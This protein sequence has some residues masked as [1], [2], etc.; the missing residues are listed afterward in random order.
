MRESGANVLPLVKNTE[1]SS[2]E[3]SLFFC[4]FQ[5][6]EVAKAVRSGKVRENE[7]AFHVFISLKYKRPFM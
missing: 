7:R 6:K 3:G 2:W 4:N 1:G 5:V